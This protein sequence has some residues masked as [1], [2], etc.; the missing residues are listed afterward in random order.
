MNVINIQQKF[1]LFSD[2]WSPKRIGELNGQQV[3]LAKIEGEFVFHKHDD[4]DELFM[5]MKG[6]LSLELRGHDEEPTTVVVNPGEFFIVPRG[7]EH[8]PTATEETHLLLFEP[9]STK[10]TGDVQAD[11]TVE[12]YEEI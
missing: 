1:D 5:V 4:E 3:I 9:L 11:I 2:R 10:H 12:T 8:K 6:Q 7:V